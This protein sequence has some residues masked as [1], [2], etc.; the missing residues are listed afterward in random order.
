ME[1][2]EEIKKMREKGIDDNQIGLSLQQAGVP[3]EEISNAFAELEIKKAITENKMEGKTPNLEK[4]KF[5][6]MT[7]SIMYESTEQVQSQAPMPPPQQFSTYNF[8]PPSPMQG[9]TQIPMANDLK[10]T[11]YYSQEYAPQYNADYTNQYSDYGSEINADTITDIT[12]QVIDE[13]LLSLKKEIEKIIEMRGFLE[14]RI[15]LLNKRVE[16]IEKIID[17]LQLSVLQKVGEY[18][19]NIEDI[20]KEIIETQKTFNSVYSSLNKNQKEK[21]NKNPNSF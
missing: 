11:A 6:E 14:S 20:K 2:K 1:I 17:R 16:K 21:L 13:K 7:P 9:Q 12:E 15:D 5:Q 8:P 3:V 19:T 10:S 18:M 4:E